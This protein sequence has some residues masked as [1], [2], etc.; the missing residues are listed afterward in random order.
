MVHRVM[1]EALDG[2]CRKGLRP[3]EFYLGPFIR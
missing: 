1:A 3:M 2:G